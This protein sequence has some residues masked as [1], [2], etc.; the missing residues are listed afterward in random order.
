[1]T[2]RMPTRGWTFRQGVLVGVAL[3]LL[4]QSL[5]DRTPVADWLVSPL[6]LRDTDESA[7]VIVVAGAGLVGPCEPNLSAVRR[8]L[9]AA[10]LWGEQRAPFVLFTGG[11]PRALSC[12]VSDVMADFAVRV[13]I[14]RDRILTEATSINTRENAFYAV[15]VLESLG[16][17]RVILVTDRLHM[18]RASRS[19]AAQGYT[20]GRASVPVYATHR[21]NVDMLAGSFREATALAYYWIRGWLGSGTAAPSAGPTTAADEATAPTA[22]RDG[23]VVILGASYAEGWRLEAVAG[24]PVLNKGVDGQ[25]SFELAERFDRDV[26]AHAP[27]AVVIWGFINDVFRTPRAEIQPAMARARSSLSSM[28]ARG[29]EAGLEVIVAT[30]VPIATQAGWTNTAMAL[31]GRVLRRSSYQEYV[32][33]H[34]RETNA[35]IRETAREK[36]VLLL[37]FERVLASPDGYR[38]RVFAQPDGSHLTDAAYAALTRYSAPIL[39]RHFRAAR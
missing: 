21:G 38:R 32:N 15:P 6:L 36:G 9:K 8:V 24:A 22:D 35:W 33:G 23:P 14:P 25:Q 5:I 12:A 26:L 17:R 10:A 13:G 7:D 30:E 20:V 11:S 28:I 19:F 1:M 37:D 18:L 31:V 3:V 4:A 39:G 2:H 29:Q 16:A 27:R 34:V